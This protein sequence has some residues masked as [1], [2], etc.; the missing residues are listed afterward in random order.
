MVIFM[1]SELCFT[2][3]SLLFFNVKLTVVDEVEAPLPL[4]PLAP[5]PLLP[6][7]PL[8]LATALLLLLLVPEPLATLAAGVALAASTAVCVLG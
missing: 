4:L 5:L 2:M 7:V 8:P 1:P 3:Y 6:L